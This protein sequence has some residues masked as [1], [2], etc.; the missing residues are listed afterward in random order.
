MCVGVCVCVCVRVCV[1]VQK[2]N[3]L[4]VTALATKFDSERNKISFVMV[5][6]MVMKVVVCAFAIG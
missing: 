3:S 6:P 2:R 5:M 4:M 1:C